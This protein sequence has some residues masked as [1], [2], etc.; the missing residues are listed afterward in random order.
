MELPELLIVLV[1]IVVK[2]LLDTGTE[3]CFISYSV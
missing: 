1:G 2:C 3:C